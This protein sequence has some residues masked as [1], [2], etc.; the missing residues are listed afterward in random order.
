M[1]V[2]HYT[3]LSY[4]CVKWSYAD[5]FLYVYIAYEYEARHGAYSYLYAR[6]D[7]QLH[8]T[9]GVSHVGEM[10]LLLR[11]D[12]VYLLHYTLNMGSNVQ[13]YTTLYFVY[14]G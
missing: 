3:D 11:L 1:S 8:C 5:I 14:V 2:K 9:V 10:F 7:V 6:C 12:T 4:V 13:L